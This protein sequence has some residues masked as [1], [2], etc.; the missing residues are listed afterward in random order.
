MKKHFTEIAFQK[1]KVAITQ[2]A[3]YFLTT[4]RKEKKLIKTILIQFTAYSSTTFLIS[5]TRRSIYFKGGIKL[6]AT[7]Y[8]VIINC[9][10][11][12]VFSGARTLFLYW[13][14]KTHLRVTL[15][16]WY[17]SSLD[18][19]RIWKERSCSKILTIPHRRLYFT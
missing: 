15:L 4:P 1:F 9:F 16:G 5:R 18:R 10:V 12:V 8:F 17:Y 11:K 13:T 2:M 7:R 6:S 14:V 19:Y 3:H